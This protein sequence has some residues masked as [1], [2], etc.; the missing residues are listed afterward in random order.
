MVDS[1]FTLV[2]RCAASCDRRLSMS[3]AIGASE[4]STPSMIAGASRAACPCRSAPP[5]SALG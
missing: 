3:S 1:F 4:L 5:N 2:R